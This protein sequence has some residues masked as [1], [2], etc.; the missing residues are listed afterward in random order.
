MLV[1]FTGLHGTGKTT[2]INKII[3]LLKTQDIEV[4]L[5][6]ELVREEYKDDFENGLLK[7]SKQLEAFE[8][9]IN[10]EIE[11]YKNDTNNKIIIFD[12]TGIDYLYYQMYNYIK[13]IDNDDLYNYSINIWKN[14]LNIFDK[15]L[16]THY[17]LIYNIYVS[18]DNWKRF[19]LN[20]NFRNTDV[21]IYKIMCRIQDNIFNSYWLPIRRHENIY[22][23]NEF[24]NLSKTIYMGIL[25]NFLF[26]KVI[27][28]GDINDKKLYKD[29]KKIYNER[30]ILMG[31][32]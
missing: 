6:K 31:D 23:E 7:E 14:M 12:R 10:K 3:E 17:D 2:I 27:K 21:D 15:Y 16:S 18:M 20:D 4:V 28:N 1:G 29:I 11:E 13:H 9:Q 32:V 5:C 24:N 19:K 26:K 25:M 8:K 22:G 30:D